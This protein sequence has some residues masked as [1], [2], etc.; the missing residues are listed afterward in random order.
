MGGGEEMPQQVGERHGTVEDP[1][2]SLASLLGPEMSTEAT[3]VVC[4]AVPPMEYSVKDDIV[5]KFSLRVHSFEDL[6]R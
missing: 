3:T 4:I 5:K 2:E 1:S 6:K